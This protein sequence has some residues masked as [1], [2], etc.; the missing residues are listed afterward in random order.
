[1]NIKI[2]SAGVTCLVGDAYDQV[3]TAVRNQL[4]DEAELFTE[5]IPG[6]DYLQ[7]ELPGDGWIS[8]SEGDPLFSQEVKQEVLRKKQ[9]I[10]Q[11]FGTNQEMAQKILS[12]PDDSYIYYKLDDN[13][14]LRIRL[15]AWGYRYPERV[16]GGGAMGKHNPKGETEHVRIHITYDG[17]P[18]EGKTLY[19]QGIE[20]HTNSSGVYAIGDLP[21]GYQFELKVDDTKRNI[22]VQSGQGDIE[23]DTTE[24]TT[25]NVNAV[26]DH[27][28]YIGAIASLKYMGRDMQLTT[29]D[30]GTVSVK[31][32]I[33]PS[34]GMCMISIGNDFQQF[35]LIQ[36]ITE[37]TFN[38]FSTKDEETDEQ[39]KEEIPEKED[40]KDSENKEGEIEDDSHIEEKPKTEPEKDDSKHE[41]EVEDLKDD[42]DNNNV[43]SEETPPE[44]VVDTT[45]FEEEPVKEKKQHSS[46]SLFWEV[47]ASLC[48][49]ALLV[50]TYLFC[51]GMFFG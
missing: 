10:I 17:K 18:L 20:H 3:Y 47:I 42:Q 29:D 36:P 46:A 11:R 2:K 21:I 19:L 5:R 45:D 33:D 1:M 15:T 41:K 34:N 50:I 44:E 25:V 35:Q 27:K 48:L 32:P 23:I 16:G 12:V 22:T 8:L 39:P 38:I 37:F 13:G 6:N 7:W 28:P 30:A 51:Y 9:N 31:L 43:V 14:K 49:L 40:I 26:L 4:E 24:Y